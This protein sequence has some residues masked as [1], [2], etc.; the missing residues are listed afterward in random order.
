MHI[1]KA[2]YQAYIWL[3]VDQAYP[4]VPSPVEYGW[5]LAEDSTIDYEWTSGCILQKELIDIMR[6]GATEFESES[7]D[8]D[9][10]EQS[11]K[12]DNMLDIVYEDETDDEANN[13]SNGSHRACMFC[14]SRQLKGF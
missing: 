4:D 11:T 10:S 6:T 7:Q 1:Q 9:D 14:F 13:Q 12:V 3:H 5:K 8:D 2:N